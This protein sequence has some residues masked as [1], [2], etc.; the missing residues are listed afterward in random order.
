MPGSAAEA[1]RCT[2]VRLEHGANDPDASYMKRRIGSEVSRWA[3][4]CLLI[5]AAIA[6]ALD[7]SRTIGAG[8]CGVPSADL[9]PSSDAVIAYI[10]V[11]G[12]IG[13][14]LLVTSRR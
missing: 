7:Q 14:V 10:L 8:E 12:V 6:M 3:G 9:C 4:A 11:A 5:S 2:H 1:E 13:V